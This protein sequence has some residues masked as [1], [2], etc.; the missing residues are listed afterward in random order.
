MRRYGSLGIRSK[1]ILLSQVSL[2]KLIVFLVCFSLRLGSTEKKFNLILLTK[3][4][5]MSYRP[6]LSAKTQSKN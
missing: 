5:K 3:S 1:L 4:Y 2:I 6:M